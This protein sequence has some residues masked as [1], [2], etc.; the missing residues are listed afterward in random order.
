MA[1]PS[2]CHYRKKNVILQEN[3]QRKSRAMV[4]VVDISIISNKLYQCTHITVTWNRIIGG[5]VSRHEKFY[6]YSTSAGRLDDT[7]K[8]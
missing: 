3:K 1:N 6:S 4:V 2:R 8:P 7:H 5:H